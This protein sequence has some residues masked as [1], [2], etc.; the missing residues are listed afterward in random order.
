MVLPLK[1]RLPLLFVSVAFCLAAAT[2]ARA[3][4]AFFAGGNTMSIKGHHMNGDQ[5]VLS[6]RSGGEIECDAAVIVGFAPDEVPYPEPVAAVP[7]LL[8]STSEAVPYG[9]IIDSV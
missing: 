7:A 1:V 5:L 8:P 6:L 3:E 2:S 9:E 4:L